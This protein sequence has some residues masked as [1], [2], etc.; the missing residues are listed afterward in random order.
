VQVVPR[1]A[2]TVGFTDLLRDAET[3]RLGDDLAVTVASLADIVGTKDALGRSDE[4]AA[5]GT[6]RQ[7][8]A[9]PA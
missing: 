4:R 8:V 7:F 6:L 9:H 2:G 5:V 3:M 1:P